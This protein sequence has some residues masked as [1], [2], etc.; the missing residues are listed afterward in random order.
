[1]FDR[2]GPDES[3]GLNPEAVRTMRDLAA[4]TREV[5]AAFDGMTEEMRTE[6]I[7]VLEMSR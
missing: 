7:G 6:L 2:I 5:K 1:M 3:D 4:A